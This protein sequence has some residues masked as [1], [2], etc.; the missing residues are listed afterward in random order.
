MILF[1]MLV[2]L[3]ELVSYLNF[4]FKSRL[5]THTFSVNDFSVSDIILTR[6]LQNHS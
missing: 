6:D 3:V 4:M 2:P 5:K 1:Y